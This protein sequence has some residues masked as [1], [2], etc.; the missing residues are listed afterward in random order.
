MAPEHE[1]FGLDSDQWNA[2]SEEEKNS[3]RAIGQEENKSN[4]EPD[5]SQ[6]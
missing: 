4:E 5:G 3:Y 1:A 6:Y 2:L